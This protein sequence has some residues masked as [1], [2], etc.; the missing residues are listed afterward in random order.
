MLNEEGQLVVKG[1]YKE[2]RLI[3]NVRVLTCCTN[4][5]VYYVRVK[6]GRVLSRAA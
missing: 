3:K 2:N 6:C 5:R 4:V 1:V